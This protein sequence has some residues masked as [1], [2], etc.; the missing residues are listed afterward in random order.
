MNVQM[1]EMDGPTATAKIRSLPDPVGSLPIV[2]LTAN[3]MHGDR[4]RYLSIGM[5]DY[6]SKPIDPQELFNTIG[7]CVNVTMPNVEKPSFSDEKD[8]DNA[9]TPLSSETSEALDGL[10]G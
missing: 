10:L 3:A 2:A 6:I 4:E 7:R 8:G 1:P 5:S 9:N